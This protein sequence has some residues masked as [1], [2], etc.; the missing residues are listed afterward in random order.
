MRYRELVQLC[1]HRARLA[2]GQDS[3][4]LEALSPLYMKFLDVCCGGFTRTLNDTERFLI[5][6]RFRGLFP[7]RYDPEVC[8]YLRKNIQ[9]GAVSLNIGAHVGVYALCLARWSRP[10]GR[11]YAFEPSQ[12]TRS[13]LQN[14]IARNQFGSS[15]QVVPYAIS[16]TA[17]E[18]L[19]SMDGP[20]GTN[21][22]GGPNPEANG[23]HAWSRVSTTTVDLFCAAENLSPDLMTIDIEG[24]EVAA[25][26]GARKTILSGRGRLNIL[27]EM[28]PHLWSASGTSREAF[29]CLLQRA[30]TDPRLFR[31]RKTPLATGYSA[32]HYS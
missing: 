5:D 21:R 2:F 26:A 7:E 19:F 30:P 6:P 17:G 10:D 32:V 18:S 25:L 23:T 22:L 1:A 24:Y 8:D 4:I 28:H 11:V 31:A 16:D 13:I 3:R 15:I 29:A 14:H 12:P 27:V 20:A 9:P